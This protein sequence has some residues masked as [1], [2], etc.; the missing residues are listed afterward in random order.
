MMLNIDH[1]RARIDADTNE[2]PRPRSLDL[3]LL[4]LGFMPRPDRD[5]AL[6]G[7]RTWSRRDRDEAA[8]D[9]RPV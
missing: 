4:R 3:A 8:V 2:S 1:A 6:R 9:W 5:P 7:P